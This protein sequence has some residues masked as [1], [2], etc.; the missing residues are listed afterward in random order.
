MRQRLRSW[1][2]SCVASFDP[3]LAIEWNCAAPGTASSTIT[4]YTEGQGESLATQ[5]AYAFLKTQG[6]ALFCPT[7]RQVRVV[8]YLGFTENV[9]GAG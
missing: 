7:L 1:L 2:A 6:G 5:E 3:G 4:I 8:G 9:M